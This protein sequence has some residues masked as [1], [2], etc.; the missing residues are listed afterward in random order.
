MHAVVAAARARGATTLYVM[1]HSMGATTALCTAGA[2]P[3]DRR[4]DLDR[5]RLRAAAGA[6][7]ALARRRGRPAL[8]VRRRLSAAGTGRAVAAAARRGVAATGRPADAVHRRRTRRRWWRARASTTC[9]RARPNRSRS[10]PSTSDHTF[11]GDNSR[12][13]VLAWLNERHA[14]CRRRLA[15]AAADLAALQPPSADSRSRSGRAR[16]TGRRARAGRRRRRPRLAGARVL[17][18]GRR[19]PHRHRRRRRRSTSPTCS[20][21]SSTTRPTSANRK[22][23]PPRSGCTR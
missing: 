10:P 16:E 1:G 17:G 4:R 13:T 21:R 22:P 19:R 11:A 5:D 6:R 3:D 7:R 9:S 12:A 20:G 18:G 8:V 15:R 23:P 2:R 14:R